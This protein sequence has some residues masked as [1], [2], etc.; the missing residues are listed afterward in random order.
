M[1]FSCS[2]SVGY[3]Y[4]SSF[5][6]VVFKHPLFIYT[7]MFMYMHIYTLVYTIVPIQDP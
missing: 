4:L 7:Y 3:K 2:D 1:V 6:E 5:K